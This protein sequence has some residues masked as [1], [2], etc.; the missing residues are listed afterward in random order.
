[1]SENRK[2]QTAEAAQHYAA[3]LMT[4]EF[5]QINSPGLYVEHRSGTLVRLPADG[6]VPNRS[7]VVSIVGKEPWIVTKISQDPFLSITKARM[8]AADLDLPVNF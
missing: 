8:I 1:M 7:P 3:G 2:L 5:S 6:V 4:C